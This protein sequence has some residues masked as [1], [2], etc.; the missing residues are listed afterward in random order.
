MSH[1]R[2]ALLIAALLVPATASAEP[3]RGFAPPGWDAE[4]R[5]AEA[6]DRNPDP[7]IVEVDLTA[8]IADVEVAPAHG[9]RPGPTT[10]A[11]PGR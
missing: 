3:P 7:N 5:L 9:S 8:R 2:T 1:T 6:A 4:A 11:C 10:A